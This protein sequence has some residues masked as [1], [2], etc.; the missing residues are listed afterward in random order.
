M[1]WRQ[2][3]I[4]TNNDLIH[5]CTYESLW[6][7]ELKPLILPRPRLFV[8]QP[9]Q[10]NRKENINGL[11]FLPFVKGGFPAQSTS[12]KSQILEIL[13]QS[14]AD[15][16]FFKNYISNYKYS[17][18]HSSFAKIPSRVHFAKSHHW[19]DWCVFTTEG[20]IPI[21]HRSPLSHIPLRM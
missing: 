4:W 20:A 6:L 14:F 21:W 17:N 9:V 15:V 8:R 19:F 13:L 10:A 12:T 3:T 7:D 1:P 11:H 18:F 2:V 5:E 16:F